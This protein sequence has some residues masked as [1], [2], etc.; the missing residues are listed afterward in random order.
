MPVE[1]ADFI[2]SCLIR[3]LVISG[4]ATSTSLQHLLQRQPFLSLLFCHL[5]IFLYFGIPI[6]LIHRLRS[7]PSV[8]LTRDHAAAT[9]LNRC[10]DAICTAVSCTHS[11]F[12]ELAMRSHCCKGRFIQPRGIR[13][14]QVGHAQ[15]RQRHQKAQHNLHNRPLQGLT[16]K[17]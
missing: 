3:N 17:Q 16:K 8:H 12:G 7:F 14:A 5:I 13:G 10:G 15:R 11:S 9:K 4:Q 1:S 6:D 2:L